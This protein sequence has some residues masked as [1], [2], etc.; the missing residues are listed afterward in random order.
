MRISVVEAI[1]RVATRLR[2]A[3]TV[4]AIGVAGLNPCDMLDLPEE[5]GEDIF[6]GDL[7]VW[8]RIGEVFAIQKEKKSISSRILIPVRFLTYS[9]PSKNSGK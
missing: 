5:V 1:S 4:I 6:C 2:R 8:I 9:S 7:N 3:L